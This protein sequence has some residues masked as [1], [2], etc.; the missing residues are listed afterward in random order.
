MLFH[1]AIER[2]C[3]VYILETA[4]GLTEIYVI[5]SVKADLRVANVRLQNARRQ[6]EYRSF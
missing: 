4:K 1:P 3:S 5:H 2:T 6:A